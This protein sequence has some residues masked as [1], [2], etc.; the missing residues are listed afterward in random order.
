MAVQLYT[1]LRTNQGDIEIRLFENHTPK[2]VKNFVEL[3]F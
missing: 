3:E 1:T 2:T